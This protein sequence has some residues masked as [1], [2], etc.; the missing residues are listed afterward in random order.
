MRRA[1][2]VQLI[3]I[4]FCLVCIM[5]WAG[6][7]YTSPVCSQFSMPDF[8]TTLE[9]LTTQALIYLPKLLFIVLL[10]ALFRIIHGFVNAVSSKNS[11]DDDTALGKNKVFKVFLWSVFI[12]I[13]ISVLFDHVSSLVTSVGLIGLGLTFALQKPIINTVGWINIL[14]TGIYKEGDR[15]K[16]GTVRGDVKKIR[17]MNT[18]LHTLL[19]SSDLRSG[20]IT[21]VPNELTLIGDV[22]NYTKESNYIIDELVIRITYES[23]YRKAMEILKQI[24]VERIKKNKDAYK[25][26]LIRK[27][28]EMYNFIENLLLDQKEQNAE[29][30]AQRLEKERKELQSQVEELDEEFKPRIRVEMLESAIS[31]I[32]QF[33]TPYDQIKKN[34][35]EINLAFLDAIKNEPDIQ[36]GYPNLRLISPATRTDHDGKKPG[37]TTYN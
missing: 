37:F 31:L 15:V 25:K 8:S 24:V 23:N 28:R 22:E 9:Y 19:E 13:S 7:C 2:K 4:F 18:E 11:A 36:I 26:R 29:E 27:Q 30:T 5:T 12:L 20:K 32:V 3:I 21:T 34:R 17:M 33:T 6:L 1:L 16:I 10:F 14:M 35:T